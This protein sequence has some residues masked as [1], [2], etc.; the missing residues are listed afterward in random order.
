[1]LQC[2]F[3]YKLKAMSGENTLTN[4]ILYDSLKKIVKNQYFTIHMVY[5][6]IKYIMNE[7]KT[8]TKPVKEN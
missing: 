1:M 6:I 3:A 5:G 8:T 7:I 4:V 2:P